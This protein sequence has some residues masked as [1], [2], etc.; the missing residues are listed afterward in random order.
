MLHKEFIEAWKATGSDAEIKR[1]KLDDI[2][3][4][5]FWSDWH[6]PILS[7]STN[8]ILNAQLFGVSL[9]TT[10]DI[11]NVRNNLLAV[12]VLMTAQN[13]QTSDMDKFLSEITPELYN[14]FTGEPF[15]YD[16]EQKIIYYNYHKGDYKEGITL[17]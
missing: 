8:L 9:A 1:Q 3:T 4:F 2:R 15:V 12:Y 13:I 6:S 17:N 14:T 16:S 5:L 7:A 11:R 10:L